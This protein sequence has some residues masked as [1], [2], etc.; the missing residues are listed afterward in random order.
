[1]ILGH[2]LLPLLVTS[3]FFT[4]TNGHG[5][6]IE[7]PSRASAWRY[8]F[9]TPHNYN[10]HEL[11]CGGFTRQWVKNEGKCGVCGDP[12]DAKLPRAHEFGG[13]YGKGIIVRKYQPNGIITIRVEI[14]ASHW[15]YFE[16]SI[17]PNYK[18]PTQECLNQNILKILKPQ[19]NVE[20][21]GF[22]YFPKDGNKVY[23]MKYKLPK[24]SCEHCILQ[25]RYI[26]G[27][28][29]GLCPNNTGAV[30]C[31]PQ[32]EFRAC[33]DITI[34]GKADDDVLVP[35]IEEPPTT[36]SLPSSTIL[37]PA[38]PT[39]EESYNPIAALLISFVSFLVA[40]SILFLL[41]F[42]FYHFG[43]HVKGWIKGSKDKVGLG[44]PP[45]PPPRTRRRSPSR[46]ISADGM[47][48]VDL[49]TE[50]LA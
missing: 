10:D 36:P 22:R 29:W 38:L 31:G 47:H 3:I 46:R 17:C 14:T 37:V 44:M 26:A 11:F 18:N 6:L 9:N 48:E 25:W 49:R 43:S 34:S 27:N 19:D 42:H 2:C 8:G 39:P 7:P 1:M 40:F 35:E 21:N 23:E 45:Q 12:W 24:K 30:G 13:T 16:F 41:Y 20:H 4:L 15:G 5:R 33:A 28:N 32:E 50:S